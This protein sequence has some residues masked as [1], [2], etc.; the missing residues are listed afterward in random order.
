MASSLGGL[1]RSAQSLYTN[2]TMAE[3]QSQ[4]AQEAQKAQETQELKPIPE[5]PGIPLIGNVYSID[6]TSPN[7]SFKNLVDQ[8]GEHL[9]GVQY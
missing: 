1:L 6:R 5:P 2:T 4:T 7:E 3:E 9:F 8:Y